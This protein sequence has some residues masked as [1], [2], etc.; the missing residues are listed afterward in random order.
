MSELSNNA[1]VLL[2]SSFMNPKSTIFYG[3]VQSIPS[4]E[5]TAAIEELESAGI[6]N[7]DDQPGG[8][9]RLSLSK[10]GE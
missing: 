4:S 9:F 7:R 2:G 8:G 6:L 10:E 1:R 3:L 5:A